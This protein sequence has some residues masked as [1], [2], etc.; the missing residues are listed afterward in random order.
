MALTTGN[1]TIKLSAGTYSSWAGFWDDLGDLTGDI[2]CT[3]DASAFTEPTAPAGIS[4][5]LNS[6]TLHVLPASFPTKT[7]ASTG[8]RFTGNYTGSFIQMEMEGSGSIIIEGIV[9][10]EGTSEPYSAINTIGISTA[11]NLT[12]RRN[13]IKGGTYGIYTASILDAG[14]KVYNNILYDCSNTGLYNVQDK[15]NAIFANNTEVSS[16]HWGCRMS[17]QAVTVENNLSY[18]NGTDYLQIGTDTEGNNNADSDA[19]AENADWGGGG[20]N[21]VNS[22]SDPFNALA[23]DDFT[24]T[25]EGDIGTAGKDLSAKFTDDFFG[26]TRVNWTIGACEYVVVVGLEATGEGEISI[27]VAIQAGLEATGEAEID[28]GVA[29]QVGIEATGEGEVSISTALSFKHAVEATGD[30]EVSIPIIL[31]FKHKVGEWLMNKGTGNYTATTTIKDRSGNGNDGTSANALVFTNGMQGSANAVTLNGSSDKITIGDIR[32]SVKSASFWIN[33]DDNTTRDIIDFDGGTHVLSVDASGDIVATGFSSPTIYI[34]N[35]SADPAV[36]TGAFTHVIVTTATGFTAS[37]LVIGY[38]T[39]WL[40]GDFSRL[41]LYSTVLTDEER[42]ILYQGDRPIKYPSTSGLV[43]WWTL[44]E[45]SLLSAQVFADRGTGMN[46]GTSA[47]VPSFTTGPIGESDNA[48]TFVDADNDDVVVPSAAFLLFGTGDFTISSW[49]K[50]DGAG[51]KYILGT[52][53]SGSDLINIYLGSAQP[54]F[55]IRDH[56]G[57]I[58]VI[59]PTGTSVVDNDWHNVIMIVDRGN[60]IGQMWVDGS[61]NGSN[62]DISSV[63]GDISPDV[64]LQIGRA[65]TDGCLCNFRI[66]HRVLTATEIGIIYNYELTGIPQ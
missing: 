4:E 26:V 47:N 32:Q 19:T 53:D 66:Y 34:N 35:D 37:S 52:Q 7:D 41:R 39:T 56:D 33:L 12:F 50:T 9:F 24:I 22:I 25:A 58:I 6:H 63:T 46:N 48:V 44:R 20:A 13:I 8:A 65:S 61:Q 31:P 16:S 64:S 2:T 23:S 62:I 17:D 60:D 5:S 59:T 49:V 27:G 28:V 14:L 1:V 21:N 15:P 18:G 55:V 42:Y 43:G 40:D 51:N 38:E 30:G 11:F 36:S 54:R 57:H 45:K 10:I 29:I 3:V